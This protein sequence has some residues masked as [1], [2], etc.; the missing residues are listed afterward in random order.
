MIDFAYIYI[1]LDHTVHHAN[2]CIYIKILLD[3]YLIS[4]AC[5][6]IDFPLTLKQVFLHSRMREL[7]SH[8]SGKALLCE[9]TAAPRYAPILISMAHAVR[10][11]GHADMAAVS[12]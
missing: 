4:N 9:S 7:S 1:S 12:H 3:Y 2:L 10:V 6:S 5:K 8:H 11:H